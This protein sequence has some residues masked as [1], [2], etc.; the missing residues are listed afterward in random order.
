VALFGAFL[1]V[2]A[3]ERAPMMPLALYRSR[4][5]STLNAMTFL[6][7]FALGGTMFLLPFEL[8]RVDGYSATAAGA[9][10]MPFALFMGVLATAAGRLARHIGERL[11]LTV[12]PLLAAA[13]IVWLGLAAPGGSYWIARL[14]ALLVLALGMGLTIGPLTAAVMNAVETRHAGLASGVNSAIAR[15]AGLLAVA[16]LTLVVAASVAATAGAAS[17][18][19]A[20]SDL[21]AFH[22][23]FRMA[24]LVAGVCAALGGALVV[25][26]LRPAA[27]PTRPG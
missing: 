16:V 18:V 10:L 23:G 27:K 7:Y 21:A 9:S 19:L 4:A 5:F 11:Q 25:A 15:V 6:L 17:D 12:G 14:P 3:R 2:E 26:G 13:G 20:A 1:L 8:I 22:R 24:M